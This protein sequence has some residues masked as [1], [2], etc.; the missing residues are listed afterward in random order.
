MLLGIADKFNISSNIYYTCSQC[1]QICSK[2]E[3]TLE[4][5]NIKILVYAMNLNKSAKCC[6]CI[7][8][9]GGYCE[10][11]QKRVQG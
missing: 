11:C 1:Y 3:D 6:L 9:K 2:I 8:P 10:L 5:D 4:K 7:E